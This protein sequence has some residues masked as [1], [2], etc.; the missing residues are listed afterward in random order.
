MTRFDVRADVRVC[1]G[2][3]KRARRVS[4]VVAR[5]TGLPRRLCRELVRLG[6]VWGGGSRGGLPQAP[7]QEATAT[8]RHKQEQGETGA[9]VRRDV[10]LAARGRV[11]AYV[12]PRRFPVAAACAWAARLVA[13]TADYVV[14]DKPGGVPSTARADN[15]Y[16]SCLECVERAVGCRLLTL[17]RLDLPTH[18]LILFAKTLRFQAHFLA[19]MRAGAISKRYRA[20]VQSCRPRGPGKAG[21]MQRSHA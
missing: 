11:L 14:V 5:G 4:A 12:A 16:E 18:G 8:G 10:W 19:G 9:R 2:G 6:A 3:Q 7:K 1:G 21:G 17:H 15:A 13:Q 20:L